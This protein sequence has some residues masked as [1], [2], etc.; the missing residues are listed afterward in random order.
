MKEVSKNELKEIIKKFL[1]RAIKRDSQVKNDIIK[2]NNEY[3]YYNDFK[4][5]VG[6]GQGKFAS[7]P[8]LVF[9][10]DDN[11]VSNG[12]YP[13]ISYFYNEKVLIIGKGIS[14]ENSPKLKW[15]LKSDDEKWID[16]PFDINKCKK[17]YYK[18]YYKIEKLSD[19]TEKI[20]EE[21]IFYLEDIMR[22]YPN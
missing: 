18:K 19:L 6:F 3:L 14:D 16:L 21:I 5:N 10:K 9:L 17:C 20:L 15:I 11:K 12:I 22:D 8:W 7:K 2:Q 1:G 4:L 13:T